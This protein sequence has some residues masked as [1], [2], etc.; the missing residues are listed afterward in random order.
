MLHAS[1]DGSDA[2]FDVYDMTVHMPISVF[3]FDIRFVAKKRNAVI[4]YYLIINH[5]D[6]RV[7]NRYTRN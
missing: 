4:K 6:M 3:A 1:G 5:A 2:Y 7:L